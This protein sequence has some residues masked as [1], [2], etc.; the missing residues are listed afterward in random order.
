MSKF[1]IE[2]PDE[3]RTFIKEDALGIINEHRSKWRH[4]EYH[5]LF[6]LPKDIILTEAGLERFAPYSFEIDVFRV[7][8]KFSARVHID[9][10]YH[11]FNYII[12][13]NG[14]MEWFDQADLVE[15][16]KSEWGTPVFDHPTAQPIASTRCN[17]IWVNT[18]TPHRIVN[19]SDS[20]R[21]CI[22]MRMTNYMLAD[23]F[24]I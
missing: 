15:I 16:N 13:N 6:R 3:Y 4:L 7:P 5:D 14:V 10:S 19:D 22:S 18:R 9:R 2:L 20:E 12:T 24:T 21:V 1:F 17:M 11:A 8:P 23:K